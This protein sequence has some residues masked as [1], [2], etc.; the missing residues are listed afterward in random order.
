MLMRPL[1][2]AGEYFGCILVS[3]LHAILLMEEDF[4]FFNKLVYGIQMMDNVRQYGFIPEEIYSEKGETADNG[5][6]AK[7]L[8]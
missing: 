1:Y 6:L 4:N 2:H 7:G 3:K 5:S 8:F